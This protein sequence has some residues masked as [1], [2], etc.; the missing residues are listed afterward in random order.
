MTGEE[1]KVLK[2]FLLHYGE[3]EDDE[4]FESWYMP[5]YHDSESEDH[6]KQTL[7]LAQVWKRRYGAGSRAGAAYQMLLSQQPTE[8]TYFLI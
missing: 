8:F 1:E 4:G 7:D 5:R 6:Y 3:I 2:E